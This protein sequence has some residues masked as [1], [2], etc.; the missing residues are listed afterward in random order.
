MLQLYLCCNIFQHTIRLHAT[1]AIDGSTQS[2][3]WGPMRPWRK[4]KECHL[5][6]LF[7]SLEVI[8]K[9]CRC[10][11]FCDTCLHIYCQLHP[12]F[13]VMYIFTLLN[14]SCSCITTLCFFF[15]TVFR[16]FWYWS[17]ILLLTMW[18][19]LS[20]IC[21]HWQFDV[22]LLFYFTCNLRP[23]QNNIFLLGSL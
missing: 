21:N 14:C 19:T 16:L 18:G 3:H 23:K 15:S 4:L 12:C 5:S 6:A 10:V 11:L 1:S 13:H 9:S 8:K 17:V 22:H 2:V 7:A 20:D